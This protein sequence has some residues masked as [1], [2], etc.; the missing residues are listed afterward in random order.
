VQLF[1]D[2]SAMEARPGL[3]AG[4]CGEHGGD[5]ESIAPCRKLGLDYV[6]C[7]PSRGPVARLAAA[8]RCSPTARIDTGGIQEDGTG[9]SPAPSRFV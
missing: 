9:P 2:R 1:E 6:R 3:D 4:I 8:Q 5:P 7:S